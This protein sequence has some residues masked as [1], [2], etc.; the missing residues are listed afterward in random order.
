MKKPLLFGIILTVCVVIVAFVFAQV[1]PL[2]MISYW[3]FDDVSGTTASDSVDTNDGT[4][5]NGP[6]WTSGQVGGALSFDG[7]DDYVTVPS[8]GLSSNPMTISWWM[9]TNDMSAALFLDK[10][11]W[12]D[13]EGMEI[14]LYNNRLEKTCY[15]Y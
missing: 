10:N 6:V 1:Y 9:N 8:N 5:V 14:W 7:F 3:K 2:G 12:D 4:L 15:L 11:N 13:T